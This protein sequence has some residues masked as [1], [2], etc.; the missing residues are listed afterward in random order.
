M[1][2]ITALGEIL[3][4]FTPVAPVNGA[5]TF[6]QNAGGA[7]AN[8][9][10]AF[11][12]YGGKAAFIG[13]VGA[14]MF[15]SF[16]EETLCHCGVD[17]SGLCVDPIHNTTLAFVALDENG[18]RRFSF[19]RNFGADVF[20]SREEVNESLIRRS[21][22]FHFGSLSLTAETAR[23]ATDHALAVARE[24]GC[25]ITFDPNYRPPLWK[26]EQTAIT[27]MRAYLSCADIIKFS[28]E[29]LLLLTGEQD[30]QVAIQRV[31]ALG[32]KLILVTDGPNGVLF[33]TQKEAGAVP[34]LS[35]KAVDTT[36]AGD[37]FFGTFLFA[38]SRA[39]LTL[40]ELTGAQI[41]SAVQSAVR[42]A[43]LSTTKKGAIAS[44]PTYEE[45]FVR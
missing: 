42:A 35:V 3:I 29:E 23:E 8:L 43:G 25:I 39:P 21:R 28:R 26:D 37:I 33:A 19:Y 38:L 12:R 14:D 24:S 5:N 30:V 13:K 17:T 16:L 32:V 7:P 34:S 18:D 1:L 15:G 11:A 20:L 31:L 4:D 27:T 45:V 40:S 10:A 22:I 36:G 2:D 9:L 44:I 6:A 41:T